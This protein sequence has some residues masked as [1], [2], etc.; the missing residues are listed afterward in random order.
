MRQP[1]NKSSMGK[2]LGPIIGAMV[3]ARG[4]HPYNP[5]GGSLLVYISPLAR[6]SATSHLC[7]LALCPTA[8]ALMLARKPIFPNVIEMNF[9]A[10][11]MLGCCVYL[12]FD[13]NEWVLID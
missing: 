12:V 5:A 11:E 2:D 7:P 10:G 8:I 9:Q 4:R 13:G 3:D 1:L 6:S